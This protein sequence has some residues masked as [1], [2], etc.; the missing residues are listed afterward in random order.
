[1][2]L[3]SSLTNRIFLGSALLVVVA[4]GV[5]IYRVNVSVARAGRDAI[6][7]PAWTK[8]R[9]SS[10]SCRDRN[11]ATSSSRASSSPTC[12]S[13][14]P[15]RRPTIRRPC[16]RSRRTTS[17]RSAPTCSS[18]SAASDLHARAVPGACSP[19]TPAIARILAACR[20]QPRRHDVLAVRRRRA[21]RR[22]HP[23]GAGPAP[24]GTLIVGVSLDQSAAE[25]FKAATNSDIAF[26]LGSRIV[27]STLDAGAS[28][29]LAAV[30]DQPGI[31]ER[32]LGD[33]E[34]IGRVQP[35]GVDRR[36]RRAGRARAAL[37]HGASAAFCRRCAG[38]SR[39]PASA[40]CSWRRC[41]GTAS[42]AR[43]RGRSGRIT[44]T[45]REMA[46]TG[47]L[48]AH[49]AGERA[50]GTTRTRGCSA[51]T[52]GQLTGALDRFRR[53]AAQRERLSSLGRLSTVIA[54]EIRNPL[55][56]IKSAVRELRQASVARRR[57]PWRA[58]IDEEV[59]RLNRVVTDVLDFAR[60]IRFDRAPADLVDICRAAAQAASS[61]GRRRADSRRRER[62]T[63]RRSSPTPSG[64]ARCSST[65]WAM[66]S[67]R[68]ARANRRLPVPA[69]PAADRRSARPIGGG[70]SR[71][72]TAAPASRPTICRGCSSRS[73]RRGASGSG[74]GLA[75]ARNIIEGLGG[76]ISIESRRR[77]AGT[78][79]QH[80]ICRLTTR[81]RARQSERQR[82]STE[83]LHS[84][85]RRRAEN[86]PGA[87][88]GAARRGPRS[89]GDGQSARSAEAHRRAAVRS[90][91]RRQPDAGAERPRSDSRGR[92]RRRAA[93]SGRRS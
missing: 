31:F 43:S 3:L 18:S 52:F 84:A 83:R 48:G 26:A 32:W 53:E 62:R 60:P 90:A 87:G 42:R 72:S 89:H 44:A 9:R 91:G 21:A 36:G 35:L 80:R 77:R 58:S 81:R 78:T 74:L 29:G 56:I 30:V 61:R 33:E 15:A 46:A 20:T 50:A 37:A 6:C 49:R 12:R 67:R 85:R 68:S 92:R 28:A 24:L 79:V 10:T 51:T 11:S 25:R 69:D 7:A 59:A 38:R 71:S 22:R 76:S 34:Y 13:S 75:I 8:R 65:C 19:T 93:A 66:R 82:V 45:M 63:A 2:S 4:T 16:G 39:S 40:P 23:D 1:M 70:V 73:S 55:M 17:R 5:A 88:A 27:A 57:R 41:S 86:P 64:C 54:H 47:D 14:K